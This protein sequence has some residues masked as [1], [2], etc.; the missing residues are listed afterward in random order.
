MAGVA[1]LEPRFNG[2]T[3]EVTVSF[4]TLRFFINELWNKPSVFLFGSIGKY[5]VF[6]I[7]LINYLRCFL[8]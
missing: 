4:S 2:S 3:S 6:Y 7:I 5:K 1:G 8:R